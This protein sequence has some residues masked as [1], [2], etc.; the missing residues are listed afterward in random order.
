VS[1]RFC[2]IAQQHDTAFWCILQIYFLTHGFK[3]GKDNK[4]LVALQTA[5]AGGGRAAAVYRCGW[6]EGAKFSKLAP[7]ESYPKAAANIF[8]N[9][10]NLAS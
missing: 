1:L 5:I 6:K 4:W 10:Y 7:K 8:S 3:G 9:G 2:V